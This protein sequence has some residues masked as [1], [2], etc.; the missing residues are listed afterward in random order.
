[1]DSV[2]IDS[3]V[4]LFSGCALPNH[5]CCFEALPQTLPGS[6]QSGITT[7]TN[8]SSELRVSADHRANQAAA[9]RCMKAVKIR[10]HPRVPGESPPFGRNTKFRPQPDGRRSRACILVKCRSDPELSNAFIPQRKIPAAVLQG[11]MPSWRKMDFDQV[12]GRSKCSR[13]FQRAGAAMRR[14]NSSLKD[15]AGDAVC[16]RSVQ[17][18]PTPSR[19]LQFSTVGLQGISPRNSDRFSRRSTSCPLECR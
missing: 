19:N 13:L 12:R 16:H 8:R 6:P 17:I 2:G 10:D 4:S 1:M 11:I 14:E 9:I 7:S 3:D 15:Q 5:H 18:P